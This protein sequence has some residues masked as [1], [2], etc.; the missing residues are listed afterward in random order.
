MPPAPW[1]LIRIV[2]VILLAIWMP[3]AGQSETPIPPA[4]T[5][6]VTDTAGL[7][8][9]QTVSDQNARLRDY[10]GRTGHQILVYVAPTT[11]GVPIEDWAVRAFAQ[12]KVGRKNLDDGLVLFIFPRDRTVRIEVGYGLESKVPDVLASRIIRETIVPALAAGQPDRAVIEGLDRI[13]QLTGDATS[14]N[15]TAT[16]D[17]GNEN[18]FGLTPLQLI[19]IGIVFVV[20]VVVFVRSPWL[21]LYLLVNIFG[22]GR[23]GSGGGGFSGGGFSGGGG[24]SGGGGASGRW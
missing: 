2:A 18:G 17:N 16:G 14:G 7:L 3:A 8:S 12:W 24:L 10:E 11:G 1:A 23:G 6:W 21:V 13:L 4:P 5:Q 9:A 20:L 22:G 19:L 15:Q